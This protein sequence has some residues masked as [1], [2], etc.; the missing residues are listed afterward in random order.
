MQ[1]S[2]INLKILGMMTF[3][4]YVCLNNN[5]GYEQIEKI[6][7]GIIRKKYVTWL[8]SLSG[9]FDGVVEIKARNIEELDK[10]IFEILD[11]TKGMIFISD[12]VME[13]WGEYFGRKYLWKDKFRK[14]CTVWKLS[15]LQYN[16]KTNNR[17]KM[18]SVRKRYDQLD[19]EI[20]ETISDN[21]RMSISEISAKIDAPPS[22]SST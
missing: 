8:A 21:A 10:C 2:K 18:D 22:N 20:L 17:R 3:R 9:E 7:Q 4:A 6:V 19:Y 5:V 11:A 15:N 12:V 1:H 16:E 13:A 14:I